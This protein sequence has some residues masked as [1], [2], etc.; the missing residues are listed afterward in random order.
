[1]FR[2][3]D[4]KGNPKYIGRSKATV[5]DNRDPA[6]K[7][8][9]IVDHPILGETAWLDYLKLPHQF[10]VPSIGDIVYVECDGGEYEFPIAWGNV[11]KGLDES[12]E[13]PEQFKRA[14]PSN[15][16][17][18]TPGGHLVE[19]DD[20]E[21]NPTKSP[22]DTDLT[23]KNRGIRI[24]S[25]ANNKIHIIEDEDSSKKYILIEDAGG[26]LIKLDYQ[27]NQLTINSIGKTKIDTVQDKTETVGGNDS[28][29][30]TSDRTETIGGKLSIV[31][32][33]DCEITCAKA[34]VDASGDAEITAGGNAKITATQIQL[35]GAV[36]GITTM[37][38]HQGVVDFITGVPVQPSTTVLSDI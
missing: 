16:G 21:S 26:N 14:V 19:L 12:P 1:M 22:K 2:G 4:A 27:E 35:N 9:I 17:F 32:T 29:S 8:R 20:G 31:V 24:T 3:R 23:T 38:S 30:V 33:G 34:K 13:I 18:Y 7:G 10:D 11:T 5:V 6:N 36:S 28:L 25:S 15:R 37:N